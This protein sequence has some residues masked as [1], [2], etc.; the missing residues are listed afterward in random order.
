MKRFIRRT[1]ATLT[2]ALLLAPMTA[3]A[4]GPEVFRAQKCTTCH[5]VSV[6]G[7]TRQANPDEDGPDLAKVG[8]TLDKKAI[9]LFLLKKTEI[10]GE[11]HKKAFQGTQ[12][13]LRTVAEWLGGLK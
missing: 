10:K 4:D 13:E 9:A 1:L 3:S 6:A 11:K 2:G 8:A 7:I 12:D 5:A